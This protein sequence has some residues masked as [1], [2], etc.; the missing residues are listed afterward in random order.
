MNEFDDDCQ[1]ISYVEFS[2]DPAS[3]VRI[4]YD[5]YRVDGIVEGN[6][7][8]IH[9]SWIVTHAAVRSSLVNENIKKKRLQQKF[10]TQRPIIHFYFV[11]V[12]L[13]LVRFQWN[14]LFYSDLICQLYTERKDSASR[15]AVSF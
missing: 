10:I 8:K 6:W 14:N 11:L 3:N 13:V 2:L 5:A 4:L 1:L 9:G 7:L 15:E 12:I